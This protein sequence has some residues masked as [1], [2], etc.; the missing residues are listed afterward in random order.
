MRQ[1]RNK[2]HWAASTKELC[3]V[4]LILSS[5]PRRLLRAL[6]SP[7]FSI[8]RYLLPLSVYCVLG[9]SYASQ[10]LYPRTIHRYPVASLLK[11]TTNTRT[12][13]IHQ[14][15]LVY[16]LFS[17]CVLCCF[18]L[19][20]ISLPPFFA[21]LRVYQPTLLLLLV[22][23]N[24]FPPYQFPIQT[25]RSFLIFLLFFHSVIPLKTRGYLLHY[26]MKERKE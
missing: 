5:P 9:L 17:S 22:L 8:P 19:H 26:L 6:P 10:P 11:S 23:E 15:S 3:S 20:S 7:P 24:N 21:R 4:S 14:F 2:E 13:S 12:L 1:E 18:S 16:L 25:P